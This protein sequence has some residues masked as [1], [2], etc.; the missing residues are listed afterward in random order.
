MQRWHL[1][2]IVC[3]T[4]VE[5][6]VRLYGTLVT[7]P[8]QGRLGDLRSPANS[9][10]RRVACSLQTRAM[11]SGRLAL[12]VAVLSCASCA[13]RASSVCGGAPQTMVPFDLEVAPGTVK[14]GFCSKRVAKI[15]TRHPMWLDSISPHANSIHMFGTEHQYCHGSE[16]KHNADSRKRE[17]SQQTRQTDFQTV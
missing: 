2:R 7:Q 5:K 8:H 3:G 17:K 15:N 16:R 6:S 4:R 10:P 13:A 9:I 14:I 12:V 11:A 1:F